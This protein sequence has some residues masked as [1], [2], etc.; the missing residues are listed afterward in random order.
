MGNMR[1]INGL[2]LHRESCHMIIINKAVNVFIY[3]QNDI[4]V[5]YESHWGLSES[6]FLEPINS[7]FTKL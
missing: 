7:S 6:I 2:E 1:L 4:N 5:N 3:E